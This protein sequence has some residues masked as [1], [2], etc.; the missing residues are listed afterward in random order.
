[1][2]KPKQLVEAVKEALGLPSA[3]R[4]VV[5]LERRLTLRQEWHRAMATVQR[6]EVDLL[7]GETASPTS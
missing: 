4:P 2:N 7:I 5:S 1:M 6:Q 3:W